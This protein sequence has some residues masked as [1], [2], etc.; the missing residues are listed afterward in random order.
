MTATPG[1]MSELPPLLARLVDGE[2][3]PE[4][5]TRL[6]EL[7][8]QGDLPRHYYRV[9]MELHATLE[10][11]RSRQN[12]AEI[13]GPWTADITRQLP[14]LSSSPQ[15][16]VHLETPPTFTFLNSAVPGAVGYF[17]SGWPVAYLMATVICG[18]QPVDRLP[19]FYVS[20]P[21]QVARQSVLPS[22]FGR[23]AGGEGSENVTHSRPIVG[24]ITGM[25]DCK[26]RNDECRMMNDEL[27]AQRNG[28]HPSSF[29]LHPSSPVSLG[30]TFALASG[31]MEITYDTGAKVILQ[32]PV[33]YEVESK[34][35]GF[36][37]L[38]KL[39][40]RLEKKA[41]YPLSTIHYPLFA[42]RTPTATVTDLGTEFGVEVGK[43]S[44]DVC[45]FAGAVELATR[46]GNGKV[47]N[48]ILLT[49]NGQRSARTRVGDAA[50][51]PIAVNPEA[52]VRVEKF[53]A[54]VEHRPQHV[55]IGNA[56]F[57]DPK[58]EAGA[59]VF[60]YG[61]PGIWTVERFGETNFGVHRLSN[62]G[63]QFFFWDEPYG[64]LRQRYLS[65]R[66]EAAGMAYTLRFRVGTRNVGKC[67]VT[68]HLLLN[69]E[70]PKER[71]LRLELQHRSVEVRCRRVRRR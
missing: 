70:P 12:E 23:G 57:D 49:A 33:T 14:P 68:A 53:K 56:S 38:G 45:V 13:V 39:T 46:S 65:H 5:R 60:Q 30:D 24:R 18:S 16:I 31:L 6:N 32:G 17:S 11:Q 4:D 58:L 50:V 44:S 42:V 3:T 27:P 8:R 61:A 64:S 2:F 29:I 55:W 1:W 25:V 63:P 7:L 36:L 48:R 69:G 40:A 41:D 52:F 26:W 59:L 71:S 9:Y 54:I 35:G 10:W 67:S 15:S 47:A 34:D 20:Q 22:S 19:H 21:E 43:D 62:G 28:I 66:V 37:S 51:T